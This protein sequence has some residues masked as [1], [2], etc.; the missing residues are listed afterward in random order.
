VSSSAAVRAK[1]AKVVADVA[2]RGRSLD[3]AL[4]FDASWS[5]QERGLLRS[6]CYDSIRWY[7]RL[8]TLLGRLLSRP[9]Q[10][11]EPEVRALAIVGLCQLLYTDIPAHAAVA[12]TVAATRLLNQPRASGFINAI[13]RRCQREHAKLLPEIDRDLAA[14]TAHPRWLVEKLRKDWRE[15]ASEI[16]DAN[17]Q[18]PPFWIRVNRLRATAANY[19]ATLQEQQIGV[20]ESLFDGT[21]LLLDKAMDVGDLPGFEQGWVSVQDAAAQL[22][23]HLVDPQAGERILDACAAPGGKTGH[24]LELA[25]E[26]AALTAVDVSSERLERVQQNLQ[27]LGLSAQLITADAADIAHWWDGQP[28]HRIL[29]DVPCSA[30]GVIRRHPDIKLLRRSDD[31]AALA[32][33]QMQ[34]LRSLWPLLL[35]GGRL[36]YASCSVLQAETTEVIAR[37]LAD[38]PTARDATHERL[39]ALGAFLPQPMREGTDAGVHGLRIAPG[40]ARMKS[41]SVRMNADRSAGMDGFYYAVLAK[42]TNKALPGTAS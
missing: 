7:I 33:R 8:D 6:L 35:P 18:R 26:L 24:L 5:K 32:A 41:D 36:V 31:I 19:R 40:P 17:N 3:V 4:T 23:A 39:N 42:S 2:A 28:F 12:E 34:L 38:E 13:L 27:R 16:L 25:P 30:T 1:A 14:R 11:L 10:S 9:N 37:F 29:L 22:A 21:A 20:T 15:Q